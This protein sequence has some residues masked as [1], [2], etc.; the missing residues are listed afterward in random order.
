[1]GKKIKEFFTRFAVFFEWIFSQ[2]LRPIRFVGDWMLKHIG[3]LPYLHTGRGI[4]GAAVVLFASALLVWVASGLVT[5]LDRPIETTIAVEYTAHASVQT[6]GYILRQESPIVSPCQINSLVLGEGQ[7]VSAG[8]VV[9]MGY[10]SPDAQSV[11]NR[12]LELQD[13]LSQLQYAATLDSDYSPAT[14]DGDIAK[15]IVTFLKDAGKGSLSAAAESAPVLKGLVLRRF[16]TEEDLVKMRLEA[17]SL[18]S[19]ITRLQLELLGGVQ[20]VRA[21]KSGY[22]SGNVDGFEAVL[23]PQTATSLSVSQID[24]LQPAAVGDNVVG[25]NIVG[26]VW[27]YLCIVDANTTKALRLG[28]TVTLSLMGKTVQNVEMTLCHLSQEEDGRCALLL[29]TDRYMQNISALRQ[30]SAEVIFA[31]YS[32]LRV[33]KEAVRVDADGNVGVYVLEGAHA[34]WKR[35]EIL[36]D[37]GENY[38]VTLDKSSVNNLWPGDEVIVSAEGLY[39]GKV[40][41]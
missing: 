6:Q 7:K 5:G 32:G 8:E 12:I 15:S 24:A 13:K 38:V 39:D 16:A 33:P 27:Y 22:F 31:V 21:S 18:Q 10:T 2:M 34:N 11:Q 17:E 40:V 29:S 28:D 9:A 23:T 35:V 19:E 1:M 41:L 26:D 3:R 36:Y 4:L 37:N 30:K 14:L 25:K 20:Y